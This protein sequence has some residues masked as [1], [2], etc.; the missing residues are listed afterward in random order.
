MAPGG[1]GE[2]RGPAPGMGMPGPGRGISCRV[3]ARGRRRGRTGRSARPG[4]PPPGRASDRGAAHAVTRASASPSGDPAGPGGRVTALRGPDDRDE[5]AE[6]RRCLLQQLPGPVAEAAQPAPH[7]RGRDAQLRA[8]PGRPGAVQ[9]RRGGRPRDHADGVRAPGNRP[10]REQDVRRPAGPAPPPAGPQPAGRRRA[11]GSPVPA[12]SPTAAAARSRSE[13]Q[14]SA[15]DARSADAASASAHSST[16]SSSRSR[17]HDP[18]RAA[19][20]ARGS[21]CCTLPGPPPPRNPN[22]PPAGKRHDEHPA[23]TAEAP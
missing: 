15:P 2:R 6:L 14:A 11:S 16:G 3:R 18:R 5:A 1:H 21:S 10:G 13:G 20:A 22:P 17:H 12:R 4:P 7:G 8:Q 9:H 19:R 23:G